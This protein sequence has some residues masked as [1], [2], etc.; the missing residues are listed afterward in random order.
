MKVFVD[1]NGVC[2][3]SPSTNKTVMLDV[4]FYWESNRETVYVWQFEESS[5]AFKLREVK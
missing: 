1:N 3:Y 4:S 2:Y 5:N